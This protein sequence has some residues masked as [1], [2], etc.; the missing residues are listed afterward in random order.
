[1]I[2]DLENKIE[3]H[4]KETFENRRREK[5]SKKRAVHKD[6]ENNTHQV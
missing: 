3:H 1:M 6:K 2:D 4:D 5:P